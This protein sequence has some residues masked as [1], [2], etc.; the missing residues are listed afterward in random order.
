M[1]RI[2]EGGGTKSI[3]KKTFPG[4]PPSPPYAYNVEGFPSIRPQAS[5]EY[6]GGLPVR[7][8]VSK[9]TKTVVS[10]GGGKSGQMQTQKGG[11][12]RGGSSVSVLAPAPAPVPPPLTWSEKYTVEGAP[13][14]WKGLVPSQVNSNTSYLGLINNLIPFMSPEDQQ[15]MASSLYRFDPKTFS[16]YNPETLTIPAPSD[17]TTGIRSQFTST[18]RGQAVLEAQPWL[19]E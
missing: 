3:L 1:A 5:P 7:G 8:P 15:T 16:A 14:W 11:G 10:S 17:L 19:E 13:D 2:T 12:G 6:T 4:L 18:G 9:S